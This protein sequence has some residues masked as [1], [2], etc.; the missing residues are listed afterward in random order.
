MIRTD[1]NLIKCPR[2]DAGY[3][4]IR[5]SDS[6]DNTEIFSKGDK[7]IFSIKNNFSEPEVILRKTVDV[8][9]DTETVR[10]EFSHEDTLIGDLITNYMDYEY[11]INVNNKDTILGHDDSGAKIFRVYPTGSVDV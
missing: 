1:G 6:E 3:I 4:D 7:V 2:G 9:E 11:D 5:K 8:E 10:I